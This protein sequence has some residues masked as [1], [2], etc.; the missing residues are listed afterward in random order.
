MQQYHLDKN[1]KNMKRTISLLIVAFAALQLWAQPV[2]NTYRHNI[3]YFIPQG[4]NEVYNPS[5]P[6]PKDVLG[7]EVGEQYVDWNDVLKYMEALEKSSGRVSIKKYGKTY[8]NRRFIQ[9]AI[10]SPE[11]QKNLE[12]IRVEHLKL[13]D[14]KLSGSL[15]IKKMPLVVSL[16]NSIH[17]NEASGVNSTLATAYFFA[18]S[19]DPKVKEILDNT[20]ILINPG[21][22]PDGINRFANWVNTT[23]SYINVSDLDSREFSEAWPSSR[24]NHYW[25]DCNRDWLMGQHPEGANAVEMYLEWM[26]NVVS[27]HHEMG[28]SIKGFYFSPG[29]ADRT[30]HLIPQA[31]QDLTYEITRHTAAALDQIGSI[32]ISKEGYDDF[33]LGKGAAY[34]D[35]QG[36]VGILYEQ[37]ASR[38]Y[39]RPLAVGTLDFP[40]TV[41]NQSFAAISTV[42]SS[43]AIKEKL[44]DYQR[45]FYKNSAK[46]A[47]KDPVKGYVFNA[48]GNRAIEWHFLKNMEHHQIDVYKLA[49][50][51]SQ[52]GK[53]Y[54][55][56]D[57]YIIPLEQ[58]FYAKA[59]AAME[60]ITEYKD[61]TFYDISTWTLPHA[62]NLQYSEVSSVAGLLGE[63]IGTAAFP[64]GKVIGGK[65]SYAYV[66]E[67]T[68]LYS[69]NLISDL[70]K[71]GVLVRI[72]RK[73]FHYTKD[74]VTKEFGYGTAIIQLQNQPVDAEQMY[75][76]VNESATRNGIDVYAFN[77]GL[78]DDHDFGIFNKYLKLPKVALITGRGMGVA[79]NGE[80]WH[81]LDR[82]FGIP[83]ALVDFN[84]L[85]NADL[86]AYNVIILAGGTPDDPVSDKAYKMLGQWTKD[87]GTLIITGSALSLAKKLG[88]SEYKTIPAAKSSAS[89]DPY[90]PYGASSSGGNNIDGVILKCN[91]D[92]TSPLGYGYTTE[93][94]AIMKSGTRAFDISGTNGTFPV[95]YAKEPYLSGCISAANL[96]RLAYTPACFVNGHGS[97]TVIYFNDDLNYRSYWFGTTKLFMNAV[98]FGQ[99]Y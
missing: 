86:D 94:V 57:S 75:R 87:G 14:N 93:D 92:I 69:H 89:K 16:I 79:S 52:G 80:I 50:N 59:K 12:S 62:Y 17:G 11:N 44:L 15:D 32:Y 7:F 70:L 45:N 83:P 19:E 18:A 77:T 82:R 29:D 78:M 55:S 64:A 25:A 10:T 96:K 46:D 48:R 98:F 72:A 66:F 90:R 26:P 30:H 81:M 88:V 36:S 60:N 43:Y 28:G 84:T 6:Q 67:N 24:T 74:G 76:I 91:V 56:T 41:R 8:Q 35:V 13:T 2:K 95:H 34:G 37:V 63:K 53:N 22:N 85:H 33:Y 61:S 20:V 38:G 31:N 65:A 5:V 21:L 42:C 51:T 9:V 23:H 54:S 40:F 47:A 39:S 4:F 68:Q 3:N 1:L 71:E 73:P 58:K 97:G 49:K 27:D 99:L